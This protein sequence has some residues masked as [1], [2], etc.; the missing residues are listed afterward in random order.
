MSRAHNE[1]HIELAAETEKRIRAESVV[2]RVAAPE[3]VG[4][5]AARGIAA[6]PFGPLISGRKG[7]AGSADE[8]RAE[9]AECA[10]QV[11]AEHA[12]AADIGAHHGDEIDQEGAR[13]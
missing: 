7:A 2:V 10:E 9:I 4:R 12:V 13:A 1:W 6:D 11:D 3:G 8:G 5:V